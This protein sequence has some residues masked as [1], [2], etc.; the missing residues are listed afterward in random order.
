MQPAACSLCVAQKGQ[1]Q[2]G[3]TNNNEAATTH[4]NA[5]L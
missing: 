2:I 5:Q 3:G 1:L 4:S